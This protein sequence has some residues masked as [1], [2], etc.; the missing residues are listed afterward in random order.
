M[1]EFRELLEALST[2]HLIFV[3]ALVFIFVFRSPISALIRRVRT[4]DKSGM[5]ADPEIDSQREEKNPQAVQELL[6]IVGKS[7][8]IA[9]FE[10]RI[11]AD[12]HTRGL[13]EDTDTTKVLVRHIAGTQL[14]LSFE[15]IHSMIFGSQIVLLQKHL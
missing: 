2:A 15:Q 1:S 10:D 12:L 6:D 4:I 13:V 14:L 9:D 7:I 11:R 8:V 5:T 3:F